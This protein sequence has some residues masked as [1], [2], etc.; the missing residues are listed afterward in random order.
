[1]RAQLRLQALLRRCYWAPWPAWETHAASAQ[2]PR[3]AACSHVSSRSCC[4]AVLCAAVVVRVMHAVKACLPCI[5]AA[6]CLAHRAGLSVLQP[7]LAPTTPPESRTTLLKLLTTLVELDAATTLNPVTN[8]AFGFVVDAFRALLSPKQASLARS[9]AQQQLV[10]QALRLLAPVLAA[11]QQQQAHAAAAAALAGLLKVSTQ[12]GTPQCV[13][14]AIADGWGVDNSMRRCAAHT[15]RS[16][17]ERMCVPSMRACMCTALRAAAAHALGV[18]AGGPLRQCCTASSC[19]TWRTR[20]R[21]WQPCRSRPPAA[22]RRGRCCS[23]CS[24]CW[25]LSCSSS[26]RASCQQPQASMQARAQHARAIQCELLLLCMRLVARTTMQCPALRAGARGPDQPRA[27]HMFHEQ[28]EL[29]LAVAVAAVWQQAPPQHQPV[30]QLQAVANIRDES[31]AIEPQQ[32]V[33]SLPAAAALAH[34]ALAERLLDFCWSYAFEAP[35]GGGDSGGDGGGVLKPL[36]LRTAV[37]AYVL[38]PLLELAP[39][40]VQFAWFNTHLPTLA[41]MAEHGGSGGGAAA[42][43]ADAYTEEQVLCCKWSAYK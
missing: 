34:N 19:C 6:V 30:Q 35:G 42:A 5:Q 2:L 29:R 25:S 21:S 20:W 10:T 22:R 14:G 17:S 1:M 36:A 18:A 27:S 9:V 40:Q 4:L 7:L 43:G 13:L 11:L 26:A 39:E 8:P 3:C 24:R 31:L 28:L 12:P 41:A 23:C 15:W 37:L 32:F 38:L 16:S 33:S